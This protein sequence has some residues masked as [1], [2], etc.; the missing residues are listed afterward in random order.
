MSMGRPKLEDDERKDLGM[1]IRFT[2]EERERID[3]AAKIA[4]K[5][6]STW[7][8]DLLLAAAKKTD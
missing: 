2:K 8:R 6:T 1:T 4:G 5:K 3:A 7:A